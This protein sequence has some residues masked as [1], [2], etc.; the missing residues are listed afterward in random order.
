MRQVHAAVRG[1]ALDTDV[2]PEE[3][4][5]GQVAVRY[6]DE[7]DVSADADGSRR[8]QPGLLGADALEYAVRADAVGERLDGVDAG[9]VALGDD[10]CRAERGGDLMGQCAQLVEEPTHSSHR[11]MRRQ[12]LF[13]CRQ[14]PPRGRRD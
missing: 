11:S 4:L 10:V 14:A 8:L 5:G 12:G 9:L 1:A 3:L 7:A 6:A 2:L 13:C